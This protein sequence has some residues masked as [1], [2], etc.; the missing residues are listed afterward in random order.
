MSHAWE[1]AQ[2]ARR[3]VVLLVED[4][5]DTRHMYA[6]FLRETFEMREVADGLSALRDV[7]AYPPDVVVTDLALPGMDGFELI[8]RL[9]NDSVCHAVPILCLSGF[10]SGSHEERAHAAGCTRLL[11]KPCMPDALGEAIAS[12]LHESSDRSVRG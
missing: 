1:A 3:P 7:S 2:A 6:E 5:E 10:G 8:R 11:Q 12:V 4:H 9:R